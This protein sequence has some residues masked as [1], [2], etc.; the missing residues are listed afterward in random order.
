MW[1]LDAL[2]MFGFISIA[3]VYQS[4]ART[5]LGTAVGI[6][7][8]VTHRDYLAQQIGSRRVSRRSAMVIM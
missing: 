5:K 2:A 1:T 7:S 4:P 3:T 6:W 8:S